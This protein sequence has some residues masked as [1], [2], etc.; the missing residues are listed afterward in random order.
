MRSMVEGRGRTRRVGPP[1]PPPSAVP[2]PRL[3]QGR[4]AD[5]RHGAWGRR[6]TRW[7]MVAVRISA[8]IYRAAAPPLDQ[9]STGCL[10]RARPPADPESA[11]GLALGFLTAATARLGPQCVSPVA[12][13]QTELTFWHRMY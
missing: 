10:H 9:P 11:E 8:G 4:N 12:Q 5:C 7:S 13:R 1:P 6:A 2:L 3:R